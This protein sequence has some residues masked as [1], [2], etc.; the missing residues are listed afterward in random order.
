MHRTGLRC[1][2]GISSC[3]FRPSWALFLFG[4]IFPV[5]T[6]VC[7]AVGGVRQGWKNPGGEW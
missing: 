5:G 3:F 4:L 1:T 6:S 7:F 2:L